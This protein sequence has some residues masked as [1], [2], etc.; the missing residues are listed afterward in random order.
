M[1]ITTTKTTTTSN[2]NNNNNNNKDD[3]TFLAVYKVVIDFISDIRDK[4]LI[5][6]ISSA[7]NHS[8]NFVL[9]FIFKPFWNSI[10]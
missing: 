7:T 8:T 5:A 3:I 2:N 4:V 9:I 10:R 1:S 6:L